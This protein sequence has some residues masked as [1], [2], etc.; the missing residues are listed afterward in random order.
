MPLES[1]PAA[2]AAGQQTQTTATVPT[3]QTAAAVASAQTVTIPLDQLN[4]FTTMQARLA[5]IEEDRQKDAAEAVRKDTEAL[6]AKGQ[7][8][9]ALQQLRQQ[10]DQAVQA[11]RMKLA[12]IEERAKRYALEGELART[13]AAQQLVPG[14]AEQLTQLWRSHF[15][16]DP[17]GETFKV[18]HADFSARRALRHRPAC[19]SASSPI[20]SGPRIRPAGP[21]VRTRP[22]SR[23]R[24]RRPIRAVALQPKNMSEAIIMGMKAMAQERPDARLSG[25]SSL[26]DDGTIVRGKSDGFGLRP[27]RKQA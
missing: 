7:L 8:E 22:V 21:A 15:R 23:H 26:A 18:Q 17:E 9:T 27:L 11:E 13:L 20:S 14:G 5:K 24:R 12:Q 19:R 1:N 4:A 25:S 6:A 3:V 2:S 10:S 16:V